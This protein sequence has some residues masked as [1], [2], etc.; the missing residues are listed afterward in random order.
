MWRQSVNRFLVDLYCG[1]GFFAIELADQVE[2]FAGVEYDRL[3]IKAARHNRI[4]RKRTHGEFIAGQ[5]EALLP[6]LM[7][8]FDPRRTTVLV[9]PPRKGCPPEML[10]LLRRSRPSQVIYVSCH[11]ATMARDLNVLSRDNVFRVA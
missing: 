7:A 2:A 11:P 9:D 1:V 6:E 10:D 8:R 5:A 4:A 3:A